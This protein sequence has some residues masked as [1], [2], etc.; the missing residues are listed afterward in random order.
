MDWASLFV[1]DLVGR[2]PAFEA[3]FQEHLRDH[4]ELPPHVLRGSVREFPDRILLDRLLLGAGFFQ[5]SCAIQQGG[6]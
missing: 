4:G 6:L 2:V 3:S 1:Q 5:Q